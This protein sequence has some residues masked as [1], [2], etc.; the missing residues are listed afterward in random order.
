MAIKKPTTVRD[1]T[2][3]AAPAVAP[4]GVV[5]LTAPTGTKVKVPADG[6]LAARLR[7]QG[8]K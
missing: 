6:D 1:L 8:Y 7:A 2:R 4:S 5:T 3:E